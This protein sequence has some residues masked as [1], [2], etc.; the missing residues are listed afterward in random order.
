MARRPGARGRFFTSRTVHVQLE[1]GSFRVTEPTDRPL[2]GIR[3]FRSLTRPGDAVLTSKANLRVSA[4]LTKTIRASIYRPGG[5]Q[6]WATNSLATSPPRGPGR[7][8]YI[9]A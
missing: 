4:S 3:Q 2:S 9:P 8:P 1:N 5:R 7:I 6:A